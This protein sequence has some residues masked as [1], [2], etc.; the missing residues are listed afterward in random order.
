MMAG[1]K[2]L[3]FFSRQKSPKCT[4]GGGEDVLYGNNACSLQS[5]QEC[6]V[7]AYHFL[8]LV[9]RHGLNKDGVAFDFH[10]NHDVLVASLR[11]RR[12]ST[13][14]IGE[15]GFAYPVCFG[16]DVSNFLT[17][18]LGGVASFQRRCFGFGGAHGFS[19]LI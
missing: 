4:S 11:T 6:I 5:E 13:C 10:H 9:A 16:V 2:V 19:C 12:E 15:H 3:M 17:V 7:C 18:E 8:I 14:L 1:E